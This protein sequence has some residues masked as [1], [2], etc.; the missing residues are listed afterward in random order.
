MSEYKYQEKENGQSTEIGDKG[1]STCSFLTEEGP[2]SR[3]W[4]DLLGVRMEGTDQPH[5]WSNVEKKNKKGGTDHTKIA[6]SG[7]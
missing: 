7:G 1:A 2:W 6:P 3:L 4:H 5:P